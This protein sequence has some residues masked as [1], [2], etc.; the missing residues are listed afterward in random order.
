MALAPVPGVE[1]VSEAV[2][3]ETR[4]RPHDR[5]TEERGDP[6]LARRQAPNLDR[7]IGT[8]DKASSFVRGMETPAH[9]R[10][11][12]AEAR[13]RLRLEVDVAKL[14]GSR[15]DRGNQL[16]AL[17]I[18]AGVAHRAARVVPDDEALI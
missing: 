15:L 6:M 12:S 14:D 13:E 8:D 5:V 2:I 17:A 3:S 9:I 16:V 1:Q 18:D 10:E 7:D 4:D 11:R